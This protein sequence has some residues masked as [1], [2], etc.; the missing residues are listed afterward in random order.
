MPKNVR[1]TSQPRGRNF[2]PIAWGVHQGRS[3]DNMNKF[4]KIRKTLNFVFLHLSINIPYINVQ[5]NVH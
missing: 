2:L 1:S 5:N 4:T 3:P